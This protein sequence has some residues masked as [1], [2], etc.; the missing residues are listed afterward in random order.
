M[1]EL[2]VAEHKLSSGAAVRSVEG[3]RPALALPA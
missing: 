2:L 3:Q 1:H